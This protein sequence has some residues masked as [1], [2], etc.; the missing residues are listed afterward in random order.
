MRK[1]KHGYEYVAVSVDPE[2]FVKELKEKYGYKLK[3]VGPLS[4]HL[5]CD[6]LRSKDGTL[7]Y[8]P[9][10]YIEKALMAYEMMFGERPREVSSPLEKQDHPELDEM[11]ELSE[12]DIKKYQSFIGILQ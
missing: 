12:E 3:G 7:M 6:F 4:Y 10:K 5:G 9:K 8:G 2:S 1:N 11:D